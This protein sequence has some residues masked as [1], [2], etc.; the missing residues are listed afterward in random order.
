MASS[1][2]N[3]ATVIV[4]NPTGVDDAGN[5]VANIAVGVTSKDKPQ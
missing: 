4:E 2:A 5:E 3:T 1:K